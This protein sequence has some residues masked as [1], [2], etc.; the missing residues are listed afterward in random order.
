MRPYGI[1][2]INVESAVASVHHIF[3][4]DIS[5]VGAITIIDSQGTRL[6]IPS[7]LVLA[8]SSGYNLSERAEI[9]I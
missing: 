4:D 8:Q 2:S 9:E 7:W 6:K 3:D 1:G 5:D